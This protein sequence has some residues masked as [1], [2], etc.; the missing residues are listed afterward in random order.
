MLPEDEEMAQYVDD[1]ERLRDPSH[2]RAYS[3]SEW[4]GMFQAMGLEVEQREQMPRILTLES[5]RH[6]R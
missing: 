2:Y 3:K 1:F 4:T 5:G 6:L